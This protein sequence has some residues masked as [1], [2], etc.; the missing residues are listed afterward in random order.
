MSWGSKAMRTIT[1]A[2]LAV[3]GLALSACMPTV[4]YNGFTS[5]SAGGAPLKA[6]AALD[7]PANEGRL[8]R[9]AQAP[10]GRTC[11]YE[12]RGGETVRLKLVSLEGRSALDA[13]EPTK[14]ELHALMPLRSRALPAVAVED[15]ADRT[16]VD[17]PFFHVRAV[18]E[19]ADVKIF[20]VNIHSDGDNADVT[21][22]HGST[23][24]VVHAGADGAEVIAEDIGKTNASMVYV[25]ASERRA[26]SGYR[27][28]GYVAKGPAAGPLVV[29][30][31]RAVHKSADHGDYRDY[32]DHS[33][34][35]IGR[36]IDRNVKG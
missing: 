26:P 33:D 34:G 23:H 6:I 3:S 14:A 15:G 2:A 13:M 35:D 27:A 30:E 18:G 36:L 29:G 25:L 12:G 32:G 28:V 11:D 16:S 31:F 20:G 22:H 21:T 8:T 9:T 17:L 24:T 7:C 10:D 4:N 5:A 19:R 1:M